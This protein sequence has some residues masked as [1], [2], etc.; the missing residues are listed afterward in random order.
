MQ[1]N[2][3]QEKTVVTNRKA[4]HEYFIIDRFETGIAQIC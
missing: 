2:S 1:E 4:L 3:N